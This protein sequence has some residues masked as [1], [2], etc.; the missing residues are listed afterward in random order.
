MG[1]QLTTIQVDQNTVVILQALQEK[2]EA[3]GTTL[4]ALLKPLAEEGNRTAASQ[5]TPL[6][7]EGM[8]AVLAR[9]AE[10][11]KNMPF[12]GS[13]EDSL[14]ILHQGRAGEMYGYEPTE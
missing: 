9:S 7:N 12:S 2:A 13:T 14:K 4:E 11:L 3:Q 6:R 1:V 8:L 5:E 10:R